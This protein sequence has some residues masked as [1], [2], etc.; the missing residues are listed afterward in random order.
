[1]EKHPLFS[2]RSN[3][4]N[5]SIVPKSVYR[6]NTIF[7]PPEKNEKKR[8]EKENEEKGLIKYQVDSNIDMKNKYSRTST[9][10]QKM[11]TTED[12]QSNGY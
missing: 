9:K 11:K 1:M 8:K 7:S 2:G 3:M 4:I 5:M 12:E 10:A 6:F